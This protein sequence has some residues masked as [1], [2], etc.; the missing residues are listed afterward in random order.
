MNKKTKTL[1]I[2]SCVFVTLTLIA[3]FFDGYMS[4]GMYSLMWSNPEN[5]GEALGLVFGLI[6]FIAYTIILGIIVLVLAGLTLGFV[7]PLLKIDG[8]KWYSI[9]ILVVAI[10][11]IVLAV[12]YIAMLPVVSDAHN[13]AKSSSSSV[14]SS[15][16]ITESALLFL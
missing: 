3:S 11:A 4:I 2:L 12:L 1:L 10:V 16:Q 8:K 5:L 9:A 6:L 13:A 14:S 7:I 15:E